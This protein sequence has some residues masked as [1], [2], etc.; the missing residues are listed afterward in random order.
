MEKLDIQIA[1]PFG[2]TIAKVKI[3]EDMILK[4]NNYIDETIKD[5]EKSKSLDLGNTLAGQVTQELILD[6]K[7][8]ESSG[9][10]KFLGVCVENWIKLS[11]LPQITKFKLINSWAVRQ[12]KGD[13]NPTHWHNGH[14]S[15]AGFLKVPKSL[16]G[17]TQKDKS[18]TKKYSGGS[19]QL[20][21]GT[22]HFMSASTKTIKPEV[23]NFYFFPHYLMHTVYPF[24]D[25]LEE[26]RS[27]SFNA[28]VDGEIYD[29]Y[30]K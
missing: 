19:L 29:V 17:H 13:Y 5:Q 1:K 20:L 18:E 10:L 25:T 11:G 27:I 2:P 22:R 30:S 15:G 7:F 9:W 26:R 3:P 23:G 16:G 21:N 8:C 6:N 14:V 28:E 4:L 24:K 12:F